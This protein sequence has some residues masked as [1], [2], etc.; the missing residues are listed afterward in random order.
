MRLG[1]FYTSITKFNNFPHKTA[2]MDCFANCGT[3]AG[4]KVFSYYEYEHP[5]QLLDAAII[6]GYSLNTGE[7]PTIFTRRWFIEELQKQPYCDIIYIDSSIFSYGRNTNLYHRYSINGIYPNDGDYFLREPSKELTETITNFY[8]IKLKPWRTNGEYILLLAQRT[9]S[10]NMLGTDNLKW[11]IDMVSRIKQVTDRRILIRLH[12]G[13]N[14]FKDHNMNEILK[15]HPD[16]SFSYNFDITYD[17]RN[18]WC[19]VG[20]NSTPNCVSIIEG[21]PVYLDN[22]E[23]SWAIGFNDLNLIENPPIFD[24]EEWLDKISCIH[25]SNDEISN[26]TFR[27]AY[28]QYRKFNGKLT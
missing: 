21:I 20:Y 3:N 4:D 15:I 17:L 13:D 26:G 9:K 25:W 14:K 28:V 27:D 23:S 12:P 19:G 5:A 7:P 11:V 16:V 1:I 2:P 18:A 10:W 6:L 24:R 8:N 22:P